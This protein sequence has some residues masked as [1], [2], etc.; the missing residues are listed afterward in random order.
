M[1]P[2]EGQQWAAGPKPGPRMTMWM[3]GDQE[4][5]SSVAGFAADLAQNITTCPLTTT[6]E[7]LLLLTDEISYIP[8]SAFSFL[9]KVL[10]V[11]FTNTGSHHSR[12][13]PSPDIQGKERMRF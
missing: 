9:E 6:C 8:Q 12:H 2:R 5:K 3:M 11:S 4:P 10:L 1:L 13:V 7:A